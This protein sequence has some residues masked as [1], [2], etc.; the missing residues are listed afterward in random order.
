M[1]ISNGT[2]SQAERAVT[3]RLFD[4]AD[5]SVHDG[6]G[7]RTVVYFQT[8]NARC[9]WCHSPQS[10]PFH[11]PIIFNSNRCCLCRRCAETCRQKAHVFENGVHQINHTGCTHCGRC[12][13]ACPN[14]ISG[15]KGSALHFPVSEIPVN[16]LFE[17]IAPYARLCGEKGGVTLSGGEA[18]LQLTAAKNLLQACKQNGIHTAVE[19]SGLLPVKAYAEVAPWV[20]LWLFGMRVVTGKNRIR[21]D[22]HIQKILQ[23]L[24]GNHA[25]ILPRIPMVPGFYDREEV[26]QPVADMLMRFSINTVCLNG[27]NRNYDVSYIQSG[28]PLK[29][30]PP[31]EAEIRGCEEKITTYFTLLNFNIY[32]NKRDKQQDE[33]KG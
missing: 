32:E 30:H 33:R 18:L 17:Q 9:D 13:E 14:S 26:L 28:I 12:I 1:K 5:F 16:S 15:V 11:P 27:W 6:P 21:H 3:V 10:Q 4:I 31:S 20:D 19:T 8:C 23:F 7:T 29:M 24:T 25:E 2:Y 22:Q